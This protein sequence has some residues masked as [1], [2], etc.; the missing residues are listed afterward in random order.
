MSSKFFFWETCLM[1]ICTVEA[2]LDA[3]STCY[4]GAMEENPFGCRRLHVPPHDSM[5][6]SVILLWISLPHIMHRFYLHPQSDQVTPDKRWMT[7]SKHIQSPTLEALL[8]HGCREV[9][10]RVDRDQHHHTVIDEVVNHC[11]LFIPTPKLPSPRPILPRM[12]PPP[13]PF[14]LDIL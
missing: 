10:S 8:P 13:A 11:P 1:C 3:M 7:P 4:N 14:A 9:R 5:R 2:R 12:P 6:L